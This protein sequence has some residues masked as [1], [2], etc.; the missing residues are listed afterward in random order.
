MSKV[1][2]IF[3]GILVLGLASV[4]GG[5]AWV[6]K[7]IGP[8]APGDKKLIRFDSGKSFN[9]A[10]AEMQRLGVIKN[11]MAMNLY[12]KVKG[13]YEAFRSGTFEVQP[14]MTA[15]HLFK[16]L[17]SPLKQMVR[18][19]EGW[20]AARVADRLEA[21]GVCK[22]GEYVDL[23]KQPEKFQKYVS[24]PL[25]K[26]TLE[27]YLYPDTYDLPPMIGA[28]ETIKIQL[29]TFD[30]RIAK[31]LPK[32]ANIARLVNIASMVECETA[33]DEERPR[34]A[35]VIENRLRKGM[36]LQIDATVLY[37]LQVWK[38]LGP[39]V[40]NTVK[41]PYNTYLIDG[42]P[43]G[44]ICSPSA[45]SVMAALKPESHNYFFYVALPTQFHL[46]STDYGSHL[47]NINKARA[48]MRA[49]REQ[50]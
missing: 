50:G 43:P 49:A 33:K 34:V 14:G 44:P 2:K 26:N 31:E 20:W 41:S 12:A 6:S 21:K 48:A 29:K 4:V 35:G 5:G 36:R 13:K 11:P 19:P 8:T 7:E 46:F 28:F 38:N 40:V 15:D 37:A 22:K 27:G 45:R 25:P 16:A 42:L 23:V 47:S 39:G 1:K 32:G 10:M 24:F 30:Q 18:I 17:N 3:G 9:A